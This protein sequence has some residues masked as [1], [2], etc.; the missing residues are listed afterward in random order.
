[1]ENKFSAG[2]YRVQIKGKDFFGIQ[3]NDGNVCILA[4][5]AKKGVDKLANANL[6]SAAPD[7]LEAL[8]LFVRY[9]GS[10]DNEGYAQLSLAMKLGQ[11][12]IAKARGLK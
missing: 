7:L 11:S 12:A 9:E 5:E 3:S 1:M 6:L 4:A 2:P 8:E 10:K